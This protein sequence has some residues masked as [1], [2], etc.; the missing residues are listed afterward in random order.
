[1]AKGLG[2]TDEAELYL[3]RSQNFRNLWNP[4]AEADLTKIDYGIIKGF[5][6]PRNTDGSWN[7]SYNVTNCAGCS[8]VRSHNLIR[9]I[10]E[11]QAL[12]RLDTVQNDLTYE[13]SHIRTVPSSIG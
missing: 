10:N 5:L 13:V 9:M 4:D 12:T 11:V 6:A 1:M 3:N 8:W 7:S 2:L